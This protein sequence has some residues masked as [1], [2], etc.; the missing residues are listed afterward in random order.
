MQA[1]GVVVDAPVLG[2]LPA[3]VG[4]P[5]AAPIVVEAA[6]EGDHEAETWSPEPSYAF[7]TMSA[8]AGRGRIVAVWGPAGAPG[9]TTVAIG[10]A[11]EAARLGVPTL[12][13][14]ADPYGGTVAQSL[15]LGEETSGL[16]LACRDAVAGRL[17]TVR[18]AQRSRQLRPRLRVLT[19]LVRSDRWREVRPAG[20]RGVFE[21]A[22]RLCPLTVVDCGFCLEQDEQDAGGSQRNGATLVALA[23]ADTVLCVGTPGPIGLHRLTRGLDELWEV[24]PGVMPLIVANRV[25]SEAAAS[26]APRREIAAALQRWG[27]VNAS[28][29]LPT[30]PQPLDAGIRAGATLAEV[31]PASPCAGPSST[32]PGRSP[33]PPSL[34]RHAAAASSPAAEPRA[35]RPPATPWRPVSAVR[36]GWL[37]FGRG[38]G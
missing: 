8:D 5:A 18:L 24:L 19:G 12:L 33:A 22:R 26:G 28:A 13:I 35:G 37:G 32:W 23:V 31:A 16:A 25:M 36:G 1:R 10:V 27:G 38:L 21:E 9:R 17:E 2:Q 4:F 14:D 6:A 11:D 29:H 30:D 15:G 3:N 7:P 20:L 34:R